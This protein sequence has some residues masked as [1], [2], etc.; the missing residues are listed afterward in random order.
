MWNFRY[1]AKSSYALIDSSPVHGW[2]VGHETKFE[3]SL[4]N[5]LRHSPAC[6]EQLLFTML[7][8]T[9]TLP[10]ADG[11]FE[12]TPRKDPKYAACASPSLTIFHHTMRKGDDSDAN[13]QETWARFKAF[14]QARVD[15]VLSKLDD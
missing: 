4:I 8:I 2:D 7:S 12:S 11:K 3:S 10:N 1:V 5:A 6:R 13:A 9:F 14:Q 15:N